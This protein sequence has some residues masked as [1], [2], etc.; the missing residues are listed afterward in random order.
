MS[1]RIVVHSAAR[2]DVIDIAYFIAEDSLAAADRFVEAV[3]MAYKRL[4][5]LPGIGAIREYGN[6]TL[7]GMRMWPVPAF[8][9]YHIFY[10]TTEAELRII[11]V[12]HGAQDVARI[13][14]REQVVAYSYGRAILRRNRVQSAA[15]NQRIA[16]AWQA[17]P[18]VV[19]GAQRLLVQPQIDGAKAVLQ[20]LG[21]A[22]PQ[23][24]AGDPRLRQHPGQRRRG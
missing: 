12:L 16:L 9:K 21:A 18:G 6:P 14:N 15:R 11:R 22:G 5:D 8:L 2:S 17:V 23:D 13:F 1:R 4:A 19:A 20:L 10:R 3:H 24:R 7:T